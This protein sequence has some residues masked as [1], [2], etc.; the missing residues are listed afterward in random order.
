MHVINKSKLTFSSD[1]KSYASHFAP[2][3]SSGLSVT[4]NSLIDVFTILLIFLLKAYSSGGFTMPLSPG[5][6]LPEAGRFSEPEPTAI[7]SVTNNYIAVDNKKIVDISRLK[8]GARNGIPDLR[9]HLIRIKNEAKEIS[10]LNSAYRFSGMVTIEGDREIPFKILQRIM[11]SC[12][13]AEYSKI[14]LALVKKFES[15]V[16]VKSVIERN[17]TI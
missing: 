8:K 2:H 15:A 3:Q 16:S 14:S 11:I 12:G 17:R 1:A 7:I 10:K 6:N 13:E 9:R 5:I 4:L